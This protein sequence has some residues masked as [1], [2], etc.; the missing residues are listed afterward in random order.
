MIGDAQ[1]IAIGFE[2]LFDTVLGR[3]ITLEGDMARRA[4]VDG[5]FVLVSVLEK[6]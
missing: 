6:R 5:V 1:R 3:R 2:P 4:Q